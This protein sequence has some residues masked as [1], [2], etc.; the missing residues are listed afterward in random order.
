M[1][2]SEK[3][4]IMSKYD[5]EDCKLLYEKYFKSYKI[6]DEIPEEFR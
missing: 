6:K 5:H 3:L 4:E 2:L 1:K